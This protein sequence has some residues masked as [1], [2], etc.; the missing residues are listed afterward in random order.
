MHEHTLFLRDVQWSP[1]KDLPF[2]RQRLAAR[3]GKTSKTSILCAVTMQDFRDLALLQKFEERQIFGVILT[4]NKPD[5]M[6]GHGKSEGKIGRTGQTFLPIASDASYLLW[7]LT[8]DSEK[9]PDA[10]K[11]LVLHFS[12]GPVILFFNL[13]LCGNSYFH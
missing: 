6:F 8:P 10:T 11:I 12:H 4:N 1:P 2:R 5:E 13:F 7:L 3:I 9:E